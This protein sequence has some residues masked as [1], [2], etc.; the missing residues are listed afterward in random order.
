MK[1]VVA[2]VDDME[3]ATGAKLKDI[4]WADVALKSCPDLYQLMYRSLSFDARIR[5]SIPWRI[6][7]PMTRFRPSG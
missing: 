3:K 2:S 7:L 1:A 4:N 5:P 6:S